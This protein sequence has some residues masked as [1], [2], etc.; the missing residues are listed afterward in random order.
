MIEW[1]ACLAYYI[2]ALIYLLI[3]RHKTLYIWT[4]VLL[5]PFL[6]IILSETCYYFIQKYANDSKVDFNENVELDLFK[7]QE[8]NVQSEINVIPMDE[9]L[10]L[11]EVSIR[12][13]TVMKTLVSDNLD[14]YLAVLQKALENEDTETSHYATAVILEMQ[15]KVMDTLMKQEIAYRNHPEDEEILY[16]WNDSLLKV[17]NS[18]LFNEKNIMKYSRMYVELSDRI[19]ENEEIDEHYL[20]ERIQYD[21]SNK[22][23]THAYPLCL[24]YKRLY[25]QSEDMVLCFIQ[26]YVETKDKRGLEIFF[27]EI[28][29]LPV[30]L[31]QKSLQ[32]I[33][34][35]N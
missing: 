7:V 32:F 9:A 10:S 20:L 12:R 30:V 1:S 14:E 21:F 34:F 8:V 25:P 27:K 13:Q 22:N 33:R 26:Y 5:V 35:F 24:R 19:L 3:R 15:N 29:N 11:N 31:S 17:I 6:G 16:M 28:K 18:G 2:A 23:Y 4:C